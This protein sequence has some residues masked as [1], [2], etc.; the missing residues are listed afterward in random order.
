MDRGSV[1]NDVEAIAYTV[2]VS[3][4][5]HDWEACDE[6]ILRDVKA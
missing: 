4:S 1:M 2:G 3:S 5:S 6:H